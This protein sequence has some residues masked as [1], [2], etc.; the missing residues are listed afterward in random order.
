MEQFKRAAFGETFRYKG[1]C[2]DGALESAFWKA[3]VEVMLSGE[4]TEEI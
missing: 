2:V 3:A 4:D 1:P